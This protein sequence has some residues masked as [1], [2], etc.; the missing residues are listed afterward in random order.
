L[1]LNLLD[2][3]NEIVH[4]S[5]KYKMAGRGIANLNS[6]YNVK[7]RNEGFCIFGFKMYTQKCS[8]CR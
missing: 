1:L 5:A 6:L 7:I 4:Y 8:C 2:V 3:A